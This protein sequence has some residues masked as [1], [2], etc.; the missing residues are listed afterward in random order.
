MYKYSLV[1]PV[2]RLSS[3]F[4]PILVLGLHSVTTTFTLA[5]FEVKPLFVVVY[6]FPILCLC[7]LYDKICLYQGD[8]PVN[9]IHLTNDGLM[10]GRHIRRLVNIRSI[11]CVNIHHMI[12]PD[13]APPL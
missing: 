10:L 12:T 9:M 8:Y 6:F 11:S 2:N 3:K 13:V 7:F 5:T 4:I 1:N